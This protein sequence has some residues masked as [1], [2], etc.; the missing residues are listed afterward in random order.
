MESVEW[1]RT[2]VWR[3]AGFGSLRDIRLQ[4]EDYEPWFEP[5]VIPLSGPEDNGKGKGKAVD[6][7]LPAPR[8]IEGREPVRFP[9]SRYYSVADYHQL[10]LAGTVTPTDVAN[11]LLPLIKQEVDV[12]S[13]HA[14]A[15]FQ[16]KADLVLQ[17]AE[18]S[19]LR[20]KEGRSL[21][22]L[23]GVP[24][25]VKDEYDIEG[26]ETCLGSV[27]DYTGKIQEDG[28]ITTWTVRKLQEA[29][30]VIIGKTSMHEF[31]LDTPGNN[32]VKGTP[33]NPHNQ[34]YYT[35][36]SSSGTGYAVAAGLIPIGLG[37]DGGGSIR[38][39]SSMC[40]IFG[41][42]PT[43]ER[44]SCK[45]GQNHSLTCAVLGPMAGDVRSLLTVF[46]T[47][48]APHPTSPFP[49][50]RLTGAPRLR[51]KVLGVPEAWLSAT[52]PAIEHLTR[53]MILRL[54]NERGYEAMNIDIPF[55]PQGQTAHAMTVLTDAATLLP[56][57]TGLTPA[58]RIMI[59]LGRVT[60]AEDY[61]IAQ[62]LR[63]AIARHLA[64]L[65]EQHPGMLIITPTTACEGWPIIGGDAE[66][67]Y[68]VNDGDQTIKSMEYVWLANFL[69]L[70]SMSVPMGFVGPRGSAEA[71]NIVLG[72]DRDKVE[73]IP[74][75]LMATGE[76][77]AEEA[78]L[79]WGL[80]C[81]EIA[82]DRRAKPPTW[83]NVLAEA[84]ELRTAEDPLLAEERRKALAA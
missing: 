18:A 22:L 31:G 24:T 39:P 44:V 76:W 11:V 19:T 81:E 72:Q 79:R 70:P 51:P 71:G 34:N 21:G 25:A 9:A 13:I 84:R 37:S 53:H 45:P 23:D 64:W 5:T 54:V 3:D 50:F 41:L 49:P 35:G 62:K 69:G 80:D 57:T 82:P 6:V 47:I 78:L 26:Y 14:M 73:G 48:S 40:G 60:R 65:W 27:N 33:L 42:K 77:C 4:I 29:G 32:P 36:G 17:A 30:A 28:S 43:H 56:D 10:Y 68:G 83:V 67:K 15:F 55:L 58:N 16:S 63:R 75:G 66:L 12:R 52:T 59:A 46:E 2:K 61:M 74:V 20:Y 7:S 38:I 8:Y 1:I